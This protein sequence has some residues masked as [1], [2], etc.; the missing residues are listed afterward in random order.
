MVALC[1]Q[2]RKSAAQLCLNHASGRHSTAPESH[3]CMHNAMTLRNLPPFRADHVGSLLRTPA[4]LQAR[5][6]F[7]GGRI[8][9]ADKRRIEDEGVREVVKMQESLG[10]Q[11]I[12]DGE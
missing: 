3:F 9:A 6:D 7:A 2:G 11:G 1:M 12:T 10:L 4:V 8:T 5:E